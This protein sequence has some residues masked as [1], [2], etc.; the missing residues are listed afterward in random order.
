M[1]RALQKKFVLTSMTAITILLLV[2]LGG[3]NISNLVVTNRTTKETLSALMQQEQMRSHSDSG[4][5]PQTAP[6]PPEGQGDPLDGRPSQDDVMSSNYFVVCLDSSGNATYTD[7]TRVQGLTD[8]TAADLALSIWQTAS[9]NGE[10]SSGTSGKYRYLLRQDPSSDTETDSCTVI[11]LDTAQKVS[12]ML[13]VLFLSAALGAAC[14]LAMLLLLILLSRRAIRPFAEN[15]SRQKQ[16]VTNAGHEIKTPLAIIQANTEAM[17]LFQGETKW[18][19]NIKDQV[20]RLSSLTQNLLALAR[21]DESAQSQPAADFSFSQLVEEQADTFAEPMALRHIAVSRQIAKD[22]W[23]HAS[24][25]QIT[26]LLSILLENALKYTDE[27]GSLTVCLEQSGHE[28]RLWME[29]TCSE[30][31]SLPPERLFERFCR[32]DEARTQK[33]GGCGIGLA[34]ADAIAKSA[35]GSIS[36]SYPTSQSIRFTVLLPASDS[37]RTS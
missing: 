9:L 14:W 17:E 25:E 15:I 29:N 37:R 24:K 4:S 12:S 28:L 34:V 2:L 31:P 33:T 27:G 6:A 35:H 20:R 13:Q 19:R 10:D 36:A 5:A 30:L 1:I 16:F 18:S 32:G 3:I 21:M 26:R 8:E 23:L 22:L 11:F 7:V